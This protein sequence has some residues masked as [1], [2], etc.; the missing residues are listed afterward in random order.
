MYAK[1]LADQ[2]KEKMQAG[3]SEKE[4]ITLANDLL[5]IVDT[6]K[7]DEGNVKHFLL[8]ALGRVWQ[9][10]PR[11]P[12][13]DAPPDVDSRRA[14]VQKLVH[15]TEVVPVSAGTEEERH[16]LTEQQTMVRKAALLALAYMGGREE[17]REALPALIG[18]LNDAA[19]DLDVRMAAATAMGKV[20]TPQDAEAVAALHTAQNVAGEENVELVWQAGLSLAELNQPDAAGTV[21]M[22]L[23]RD[24]LAKKRYLDRETDWKHP[25]YRNLS[26]QEQERFLINTMQGARHLDVPEVQAAIRKIAET[27]PSVR[28]REAG[29][30]ILGEK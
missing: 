22:L 6:A 12:A 21:M 26:E 13:M 8:L 25:V 23:S 27:D 1:V 19:E 9:I 30:Q 10:D 29:K 11:Q 18:K 28:V 4:R 5:Q 20:A 15:Y 7:P 16:T 24:E 2:M 17:A 14:V 3:M